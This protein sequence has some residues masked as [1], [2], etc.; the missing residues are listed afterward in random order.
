MKKK[1]LYTA[2]FTVFL[3]VSVGGC[4]SKED[5]ETMG[6]HAAGVTI[7]PSATVTI[8][9]VVINTV[10]PTAEPTL[11]NTP[12]PVPTL[13]NTPVPTLAPTPTS[14]PTNTPTPTCTPT[15]TA[16]GTPTPTPAPAYTF[17]ETAHTEMW[18]TAKVYM[19]T[20]PGTEGEVIQ[21]VQKNEKIM[22]IGQCNETNW[23]QI[24]YNNQT[25][26]M[27]N[28]YVTDI[29]PTPTPTPSPR[30]TSTP[31][32]TTTPGPTPTPRVVN[33]DGD[34]TITIRMVGDALIH[35]GIYKQCEQSDGS[36]N[37]DKLFE[38]VKDVIRDA[39]I[40]IINQETILVEDPDDY[41]SYPQFGSP[42]AIGQG[43]IDAGFDV[44]A[45]ATNHT[46]DKGVS[47]VRQTLDFWRD[48]DVTVLGIHEN[49]E[50][51]DID[52]VSCEGIV[53][54]F[55]NYTYGLNGLESKMGAETYIVDL[56]SDKNIEKTVA[57]AK[58]NSDLMIAVLHVGTEYV[59]TPSNYA[60]KQVDRFIDA[61]ADIVLC[62]HP[63][64][65]ETYGMRTTKN[66]NTA[67]VYYS[68]G[69]FVSYQNKVPRMLGGMAD[70]TIGLTKQEDSSYK[71]E[72][73]DYDMIP[74][75]T[76]L[77]SK[78][79]N[80]TYFL[81]DY[82]EELCSKHAI[83]KEENITLSDLYELYDSY[84]NEAAYLVD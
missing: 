63:H 82:T 39:D 74:L 47:G 27:C 21:L 33:F 2:M 68:L 45:H 26:F 35:T 69:N 61:G 43:A 67:L 76:H 15:P 64:V 70:I 71:V 36:Y 83:L 6:N 34:A 80:T 41:S 53:I 50:E 31:R 23:Y 57:T 60:I 62:A 22:V 1:F 14:V 54:S 29:K 49:A 11:T 17:T 77:Q 37:A 52:Y 20:L 5:T 3:A 13:T 25:G 51:S 73:V 84:V 46:L 28:D 38:N 56:L 55:V 65:V 12:T 58:K 59:Y 19:R 81:S 7:Q 48:K 66:N 4:K 78:G 40:A 10:I 32:P 9:P 24:E 75:V 72:I 42:Y 30:P 18:T 79:K 44:I 8:A 16:T